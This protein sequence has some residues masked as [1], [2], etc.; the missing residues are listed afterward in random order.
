MNKKFIMLR[1]TVCFVLTNTT[2]AEYTDNAYT[3]AYK[4]CEAKKTSSMSTNS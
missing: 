4:N 3:V 1:S 2:N